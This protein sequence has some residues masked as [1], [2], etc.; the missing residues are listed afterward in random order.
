MGLAAV[1][2][3][4]RDWALDIPKPGQAVD[5][6]SGE[7]LPAIPALG[8][9]ISP[10]QPILS[11]NGVPI[12]APPVEL[13]AVRWVSF[14]GEGRGVVGPE[15]RIR[16]LEALRDQHETHGRVNS[17]PDLAALAS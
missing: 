4:I 9:R 14:G 5:V 12:I 15:G 10:I 16:L 3:A 2:G 6:T 11:H 8:I 17:F 13:F 1:V 7:S